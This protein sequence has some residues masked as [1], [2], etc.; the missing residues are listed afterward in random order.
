MGDLGR[1]VL[2]NSEELEC[3]RLAIFRRGSVAGGSSPAKRDWS[4]VLLG[5]VLKSWAA[6]SKQITHS[7]FPSSNSAFGSPGH[8]R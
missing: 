6:S 7:S 4:T 2:N 5:R 1:C 8:K 3:F